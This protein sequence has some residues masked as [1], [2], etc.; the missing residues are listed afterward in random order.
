MSNEALNW[1]WRQTLKTGPKFVLVAL[2][3]YADER[4]S[5]FPSFKKI[6]ERTGYDQRTIGRHV[7]SLE[8]AGLLQRQ[9]RR[10]DDGRKAGFRFFLSVD[11]S[12]PSDCPVEDI[13][14]TKTTHQ[15][16]KK[17]IATV[18]KCRDNNPQVN[19]QHNHQSTYTGASRLKPDLPSAE[20]VQEV[21]QRWNAMAERDGFPQIQRMTQDRLRC[22]RSRIAECDGQANVVL[23]VIDRV[24]LMIG[25]RGGGN[26]SHITFDWVFAQ[27]RDGKP[28]RFLAALEFNPETQ[29]TSHDRNNRTPKKSAQRTATE[30]HRDARSEL[31]AEFSGQGEAGGF[32]GSGGEGARDTGPRRIAN[33]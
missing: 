9:Q 30:V 28:D 3:D 29:E 10:Y 32:G 14:P 6:E 33:H 2:A 4:H 7:K 17:D 24:P 13:N 18:S 12:N 27:P 19:H 31:L 25:W 1:A 26:R 8:D 20:F 11:A 15:P 5:C 22:L 21:Q 16:D 23:T